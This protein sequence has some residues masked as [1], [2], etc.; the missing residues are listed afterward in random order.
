MKLYTELYNA[1]FSLEVGT[2]WAFVLS[3]SDAFKNM[4]T[5][6]SIAIN[7]HSVGCSVLCFLLVS[8]VRRDLHLHCLVAE[9]VHHK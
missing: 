6:Y 5:Y 1:F 7:V 4:R 3:F 2:P 8:V 9:T